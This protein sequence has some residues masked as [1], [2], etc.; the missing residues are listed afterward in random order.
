MDALIDGAS[1]DATLMRE[2]LEQMRQ[3]IVLYE[4]DASGEDVVRLFNAQ[5]ALVLELPPGF[6]RKGL[7]R[8]DL[9][10]F[11]ALRG[12]HP[13]DFD[14]AA[15]FSVMRQKGEGELMM[16]SPSGRWVQVT[17][18]RRAAAG[19]TLT[20]YTDV[21]EKVACERQLT[22]TRE[23]YR[24]LAEFA[25]TG[26]AKLDPAGRL[27]FANVAALDLLDRP[28]EEVDLA[29]Q[30]EPNDDI[31]FAT[32][33]A[34][35]GRFEADIRMPYLTRHVIVS[36]HTVGECGAKIISLADVTRLREARSQIEH[37]ACHDSLTGLGNRRQFN[38]IW[39]KLA[40]EAAA[41]TATG[42]QHLIALDL[43]R[44]KR[45][46]DDHGHGV[47]DR[48]LQVAASRIRLAAGEG[49]SSFRL[50]GDEFAVISSSAS[51]RDAVATA[52]A[53]IGR[54]SE[55]FEIDGLTL[56][57]GCSAGIA[58]MLVDGSTAAEVQ[59]AA[60]VALYQV[61]RSGRGLVACFDPAQERHIDERQRL[62][63]DLALAIARN[64]FTLAY[65]PQIDLDTGRIVG[66]EALLRWHNPRLGCLVSPTDFVPLAEA[67]G[68]I[69]LIDIWV[70]KT[71]IAQ[72]R[73]FLDAGL[74]KPFISIN[75]SPLTLKRPDIVDL[76]ADALAQHRVDPGLVEIEITE[77]VAIADRQ[78]VRQVLDRIRAGGMRVAIDDFGAGHS[79]LAYIQSLAVDRVKI[80][81][82]IIEG[83]GR[84]DRT[85][86]V[87]ASIAALCRGLGL[88]L[89]AEGIET[90]AQWQTLRTLGAIDGQ[91][92]YLGVPDTAQALL[93][94]FG[95]DGFSGQLS[96]HVA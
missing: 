16:Q 28:M 2:M 31:S 82:S 45:I 50:G 89:T 75:M 86:A 4:H 80:D 19:G 69:G 85:L 32:H 43:D 44:F 65:Q 22:E 87:V 39:Q 47:G 21:S 49:A 17:W 76:L 59:R 72:I 36:V 90:E 1:D 57:I 23:E 56:A 53:I 81:R 37:M 9:V 55:P 41:G 88:R 27:V 64:E 63:S 71:A 74:E 96:P 67:L 11:C 70:M 42:M 15:Y 92:F 18:R 68:L 54:L 35:G 52:E 83:L 20:L 78:S 38:L 26:I 58:T 40:A 3:G 34:R 14:P 30:I 12:D 48:L 79:S 66:I 46:N 10:N 51:R 6:I 24:T 13:A 95:R 91:G 73:Q 8:R 61:K 29:H 25:P 60:D 93:A 62:E 7:R 5:A 77:G 94:R 84:E 33:L